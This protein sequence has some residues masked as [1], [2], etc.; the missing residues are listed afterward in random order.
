MVDRDVKRM[1]AGIVILV[2]L[3]LLERANGGGV[4]C[5]Y[6]SMHI[7]MYLQAA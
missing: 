6:T 4:T 5:A 2:E 3:D 7:D 1:H